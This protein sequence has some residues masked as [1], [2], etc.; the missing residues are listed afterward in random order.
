MSKLILTRGIPGSG[1]STWAKEWV[2]KDPSTR[3]RFNWDDMRN[4]MGKYWV[5]E[6]E[7]T[8]ILSSMI[9]SGLKA[10]FDSNFDVVIDN[11]N[12]SERSTKDFINIANEYNI[13]VEYMDFKT[14]LEICIERDS[15]RENPI[16]ENVI[17]SI[18]EKNK[19]FYE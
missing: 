13:E 10:A 19:W 7:S 8:K 6:R 5:P 2:L 14:P 1:K 3:V 11:M 12:L 17:R 4:M 16:T 9:N 15:K 18:Y